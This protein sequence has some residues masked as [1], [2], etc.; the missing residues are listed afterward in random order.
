MLSVTNPKVH[1]VMVY[2]ASGDPVSELCISI[3]Q[4]W[5][6]IP[7]NGSTADLAIGSSCNRLE[8]LRTFPRKTVHSLEW[9][10][11]NPHDYLRR[12]G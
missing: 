7:L 2:P 4:G 8:K 6:S 1:A 11:A 12:M 5:N 3:H 9:W 10:D